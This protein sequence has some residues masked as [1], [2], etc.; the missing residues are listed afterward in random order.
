[1][2][3][4][5]KAEKDRPPYFV[6]IYYSPHET[7]KD[8]EPIAEKFKNADVFMPEAFGWVHKEPV[9]LNEVSRGEKKP[10]AAL[11]E[12]GCVPQKDPFYSFHLQMLNLIYDSQKPIAIVD[13]P[14]NHPL[15][16]KIREVGSGFRFKSDFDANL[17]MIKEHFKK[18]AGVEKEREEYILSQLQPAVQSILENNPAL[19]KQPEVRVLIALGAAHTSLFHQLKKSE[20]KTSRQFKDELIM[21][22]FQDEMIRRYWFNKEVGDELAAKTLFDIIFGNLFWND[23]TKLTDD[24]AKLIALK[25]KIITQFNYDEIKGLFK[26]FGFDVAILYFLKPFL[27][28]KMEGKGIKFPK[29]E[30]ELNA[31]LK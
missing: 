17:A 8:L 4:I 29:S 22:S 6:D 13:V 24:S 28:R 11:Q 20:Y 10:E 16:K 27:K 1:M 21:F 2:L 18:V 12:L 7:S 25:R 19:Q 3:P 5:E 30:Q 31:L 9:V 14:R 15:E 23:F 26:T